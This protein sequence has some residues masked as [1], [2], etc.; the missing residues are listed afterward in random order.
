MSQTCTGMY[1]PNPST[2]LTGI[3]H[4]MGGG[5]FVNVCKYCKPNNFDIFFNLNKK[6]V[7][8]NFKGK[9]G[10][11]SLNEVILENSFLVKSKKRIFNYFFINWMNT[12]F[13]ESFFKN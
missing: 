6:I 4:F 2:W 12:F 7:Y 10:F 11:E 1:F 9:N 5:N 3:Y 13:T 8:I